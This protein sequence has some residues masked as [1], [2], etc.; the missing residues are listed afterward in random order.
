MRF[1][2]RVCASMLTLVCALSL[3]QNGT[4][5][6]G[7]RLGDAVTP[8]AYDLHLT[9][10]PERT[11][12]EGEGSVEL[13]LNRPARR[14]WINARDLSVNGIVMEVAG[15]DIAGVVQDGD[16]QVLGLAFAET[17]PAGD[18]RLKFRWKGKVESLDTRGVF[19]QQDGGEW[20]LFTQFQALSARRAFPCFDE[21][22]WKTP[23]R[24]RL[25]VPQK[26]R[27]FANG[28]QVAEEAAAPGWKTMSFAPTPALPS[29]LVAFAVGPF[30]VV[31]GG[32]AGRGKT[33]LRYIVPRGRG[34]E[35]AYAREATP[36]IL[37]LLEDYFGT[38]Y[39]FSKLD[40]LVIPHTVGFAAMENAALIT[41]T[42]IAMLGKPEDAGERFK[43]RFA[44]LAAHEIAHQWFGNWVTMA[45]WDDLWL[46]ESFA[47]WL[48]DRIVDRYA[49]EWYWTLRT[50]ELRRQA[51]EVDRL[52]STRIVRQPVASRDDLA[53]A[54][55]RI[56]Y[57]KGGAVLG[58]FEAW[59]G[60]ERFRDGVRR[61][62]AR[63]P[64]GNATADDFFAALAVDDPRVA[65]AF[66]GFIRSPGVPLVDVALHCQ[67]EGN[68]A[69][70]RQVRFLPKGLEAP[71]AAPW[72]TPFCLR[73][74]RG[75]ERDHTCA[76]LEGGD[77]AL[78]L[79]PAACPDFVL[80]NPMGRSY[81]VTRHTPEGL[82]KLLT[83][84]E[85]LDAREAISLL[86]DTEL[87]VRAGEL[88]YAEATPVWAW[89]AARPELPVVATAAEV[90]RR[91]P[92]AHIADARAFQRWVAQHFGAR[93]RAIG[94]ASRPDEPGEAEQLRMNLVP[95][96]AERGGDRQLQ[97]AARRLA[98]TWLKRRNA[99]ES[100]AVEPVLRTA[101]RLG[102]RALFEEYLGAARRTR[103]RN[104]RRQIVAAMGLFRGTA[105]AAFRASLRAGK[106]D[107][108]EGLEAL[109]NAL[110]EDRNR[111]A[112]LA[113]I[114]REFPWLNQALPH[115]SLVRVPRWANGACTLAER[116][117]LARFW[118]EKSQGFR[119]GPRTLALALESIDACLAAGSNERGG[120]SK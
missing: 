30:D 60:P 114:E 49:P 47:T 10:D 28:H 25:T 11:E 66:S 24:I 13:S 72:S 18:A 116:E 8:R 113:W 99:L 15:K 17:L 92:A 31:D 59:L 105:A 69:R 40:S 89:G 55:D 117:T 85:S 90:L 93:A 80:G 2:A 87:L 97:Q 7:M 107:P 71:R 14:I 34:A 45:W 4:P 83:E 77:G 94:W 120:A 101:A 88:G 16:D 82:A 43:Q 86:L 3:A 1:L 110:G 109:E 37:E 91:I 54:F 95:L 22:H 118:T 33:P 102:D 41:Y 19:R 81:V 58:T 53:N 27:A 61:Y 20:Y 100:A 84:G 76:L 36:K 63:H 35:V 64:W 70:L 9:L 74:Q 50:D 108:R 62:L 26:L 21:P 39:P 51:I 73:S 23:W 98:R 75:A 46:N 6:P 112:T 96:V 103:D 38:P 32:H 67:G 65:Q 5:Q 106:L 111:S 56:T 57:N 44:A 78:T 115:E 42:G 119:G 29:Y 68:E 79:S 12:F 48:A 52:P 104:E